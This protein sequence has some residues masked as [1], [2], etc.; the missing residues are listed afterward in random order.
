[1]DKIEEKQRNDV[2]LMKKTKIEELTKEVSSELTIK[3]TYGTSIWDESLYKVLLC[4]FF[5]RFILNV[6]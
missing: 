4:H 5:L 2:F 1:M 6:N 3:E